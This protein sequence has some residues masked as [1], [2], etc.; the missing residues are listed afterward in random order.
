MHISRLFISLMGGGGVLV[1]GRCQ[2]LKP[3]S[4][5][6]KLVLICVMERYYVYGVPVIK[7]FIFYNVD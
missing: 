4:A 1:L 6:S 5:F 3:C 2:V 7:T